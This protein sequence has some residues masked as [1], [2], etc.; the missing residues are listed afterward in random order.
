MRI[1]FV[2]Q[3]VYFAACALEDPVAGVDPV[4]VDLD[5]DGPAEPLRDAVRAL[6]P[7]VVI[8]FRPELVPAGALR[9]LGP[10][11]VRVGWLT[12][13]LPRAED[14]HP[15]LALRLE[16]LER[17]DAGQ[18]D[19][20]VSFD[21]LVVP[22]AETVVP[23]WRSVPLPVS[24]RLFAPVRP[25]APRPR[26]LFVGRSTEHR[27][28]FLGPLKHRHELLHLAHGVTGDRL[29]RFMADADVAINLHNEPYPTFENRV[30]MSLAAG[31]LVV[32]EPLSPR[33]G[34]LPRVHYLEADA[35]WSMQAYG[36]ALRATPE[37][38][39]AV[40]LAGRAAAERF[41]ASSVHARLAREAIA[42]V[43]AS[44]RRAA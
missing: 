37:A 35:P 43:A 1:A 33:H 20:I 14:P 15:D 3:R 11:T 27:E 8:A 16:Y 10:R 41:R 6:A 24:D 22:A 21:P 39:R 17:I 31:L 28:R 4:F 25:S 36:E 30:Q 29:A 26:M 23:V 18:F 12:E 44:G 19:R 34:L 40:R 32:S 9:G 13:P 2:G 7:D 5:P 42:D 38:F